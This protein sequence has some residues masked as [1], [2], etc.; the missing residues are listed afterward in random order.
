MFP[1]KAPLNFFAGNVG[2]AAGAHKKLF[3]APDGYAPPTKK[4]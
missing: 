3:Q 2:L 1:A 4:P